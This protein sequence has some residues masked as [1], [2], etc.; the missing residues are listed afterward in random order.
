MK[1][2]RTNV[3][4]LIQVNKKK[5]DELEQSLNIV[6]KK[7]YIVMFENHLKAPIKDEIINKIAHKYSQGRARKKKQN[8][9]KTW[10]N[11]T[12]FLKM[13]HVDQI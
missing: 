10:S 3:Q 6:S 7:K 2:E 8:R 5:S 11:E 1:K 4:D 12:A 9:K 13:I